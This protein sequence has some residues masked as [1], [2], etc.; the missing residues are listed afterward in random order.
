MK[1]D[2]ECDPKA[3]RESEKSAEKRL[4]QGD[5]DRLSEGKS[6]VKK[7]AERERKDLTLRS[8]CACGRLAEVDPNAISEG[9]HEAFRE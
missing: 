9:D 2:L 4:A 7:S 1:G 3:F 6:E 8:K 5:P